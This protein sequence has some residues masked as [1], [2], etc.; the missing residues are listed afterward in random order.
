MPPSRFQHLHMDIVGPLPDIRWLQKLSYGSRSLHT[1]AGSHSTAGHYGRDGSPR[2]AVRMDNQLRMPAHHHHRPGPAIRV[3]AFPL[4]GQHLRHPSRTTAFHLAANGL[5]ER[6]HRTLKA[7]IMCRAQERWAEAL[8]F[9]LLGMRT[10]F[11]EDLQASV[12]EL[13]YGEA[14]R[15]PGGL[16]AASPTT[17]DARA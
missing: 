17:G 2:P 4:P 16:L 9:V 14:L 15:I 11:K 8:P 1:L 12:A 6:M 13:V 7:A 5:V 10:S 3:A